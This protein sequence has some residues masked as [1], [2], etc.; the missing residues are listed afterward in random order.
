MF[1]KIDFF[2]EFMEKNTMTTIYIFEEYSGAEL[3]VLPFEY[4][5]NR[6]P[7]YDN[8]MENDLI[9]LYKTNI[10]VFEKN[11]DKRNII[12]DIY[13]KHGFI[14]ITDHVKSKMTNG[15]IVRA[16]D[17]LIFKSM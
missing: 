13:K 9:D 14:F 16:Y 6:G 10:K 12:K 1:G 2:L 8:T 11:E 4:K 5:I 17:R 3:P 15:S 7:R